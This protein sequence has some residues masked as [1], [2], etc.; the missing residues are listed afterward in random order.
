MCMECV[1][2]VGTAL[3]AGTLIGGP[4]AYAGYRRVRSVLGLSDTSVAARERQAADRPV[5]APVSTS[6]S[7]SRTSSPE[8][9][10]P[11]QRRHS[12]SASSMLR[13]SW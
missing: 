4:L 5:I 7:I 8:N 3:H 1:G 10:V 11:E 6:L 9:C 12:A 13:G 2:G